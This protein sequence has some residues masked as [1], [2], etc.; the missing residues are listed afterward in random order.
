[1]SLLVAGL[2]LFLGVHLVPALPPLRQALFSR[3]GEPRYK[4]AF[5]LLSAAGLVLIVI[6][7]GRAPREPLLF[8]PVPT[9]VA[10]APAAM[11]ASFVLF[12]AANMRSHLRRAVQ[13]PMLLGLLL[14]SAVHLLANGDL[15]S[16]VLFGAFA[17]FAVVDLASAVARHAVKTFEPALRFDVI[18]VTAGVVLALAFMVFHRSLFG[19]AV[20]PF[21]M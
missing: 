1:L 14:W 5:A 11:V 17:A 13:H 10:L 16:T 19:V 9:A 4:G 20:V 3:L 6:G 12:A 21:G 2:V 15:R 7:F 8:A 18:A